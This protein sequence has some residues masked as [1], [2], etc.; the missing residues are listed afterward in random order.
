MSPIR[1]HEGWKSCA[2]PGTLRVRLEPRPVGVRPTRRVG[3]ESG[4]VI[5]RVDQPGTMCSVAEMRFGNKLSDCCVA[6]D[7][8]YVPRIR[9]ARCTAELRSATM[10]VSFHCGGRRLVDPP[11]LRWAT[12]RR[13]S[14]ASAGSLAVSAVRIGRVVDN[15]GTPGSSGGVAHAPSSAVSQLPAANHRNPPR[16]RLSAP[17]RLLYSDRRACVNLRLVLERSQERGE[18]FESFTLLPPPRSRRAQWRRRTPHERDEL[19]T[20]RTRRPAAVRGHRTSL[21]M[22]EEGCG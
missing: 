1:R 7:Q 3:G 18:L 19:T 8:P 6:D 22:K 14:P 21:V 15:P 11:P 12:S 13:R 20:L 10:L 2:T 9:R 16:T 17:S 4:E 5:W